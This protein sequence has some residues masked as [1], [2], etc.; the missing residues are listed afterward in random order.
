[1]SETVNGRAIGISN[2][3]KLFY[4]DAGITKGDVIDYYGRIYPYMAPHLHRRPVSFER[5]P[6]GIRGDHFFQKNA[7]DYFPEWIHTT[8]LEKQGGTVDYVVIEERA[9]LVF[10]AD[11]AAL[12]I[13][14]FLSTA[15]CPGCPDRFVFDL[16]P[17]DGDFA[18]VREAAGRLRDVLEGVGLHPFVMTTGSKGVH[19][20]TPIVPEQAYDNVRAFARRVAERAVERHPNRLTLEQ[21]IDKR[22]GR[23]Y[24]DVLR[25]AYGQTG[26][27]PYSLR[28]RPG[29]PVATPI[30]W[31]ELRRATLCPGGT[32]L[33]NVFRRLGQKDDPWS[34]FAGASESLAEANERLRREDRRS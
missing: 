27:C 15:D 9:T 33:R 18:P 5:Y 2:R 28:A 34:G 19:V 16:D 6:D 7:S 3:D 31:A 29:A 25:N 1:M 17:P 12:P 10:L 32:T 14:I 4:P 21:R 23:V 30:D 24:L 20:T 11:Q 13:H 26:V 22:D 8:E